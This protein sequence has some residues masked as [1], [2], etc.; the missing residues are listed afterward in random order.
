MSKFKSSGLKP[1]IISAIIIA[2]PAILAI[3]YGAPFFNAMIALFA[4]LMAWEWSKIC[5]G[6]YKLPGIILS[7]FSALIPLLP[8]MGL[9]IFE[10]VYIAPVI[11]A[12]L[13]ALCFN[14]KGKTW[15]A[16]GAVYIAL[17]IASFIYLRSVDL[18]GL[19]LVYYTA[20]LVS[21]TDTGGFAFGIS[22][23]GPKLAPKIS[24]KKTWA[25]LIGGMLG[26]AIISLIFA[27]TL[28]WAEPVYIILMSMGLAIIAQV[29]DLFESH[30]K[31]VFGVKDSSHII[32]GHGGILDRMDGMMSAGLAMALIIILSDHKVLAWF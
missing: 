1:R 2:I 25:G 28:E 31:R 11:C 15:F 23:G 12:L 7:L 29:G 8:F 30:A 21:A 16:I 26:A 4:G 22:I 10:A 19:E 3:Q 20:F 9:S 6:E 17:P 13:F 24:P 32:P 5:L 27:L 14:Q 18:I